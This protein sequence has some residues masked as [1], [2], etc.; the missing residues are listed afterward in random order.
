MMRLSK[1]QIGQRAHTIAR[2]L[3][4]SSLAVEV[5]DGESVVGGGAA[6]SAVL[7]TSLLA[8]AIKGLSADELLARLRTT[9]PP[10]VARVVDDRVVLDL[11]TVLSAQDAAI[12]AALQIIAKSQA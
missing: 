5:I 7:P 10:I 1:D 4:A 2:G 12:G 8:V 6:P 11:R 9:D 3:S